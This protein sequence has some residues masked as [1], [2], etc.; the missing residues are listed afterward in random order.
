MV[1]PRAQWGPGGFSDGTD[2]SGIRFSHENGA[3]P[4]KFMPETMGGGGLIFDYDA[5]GWPDIFLVD[6]GSLVD[7]EAASRAGHRLYRNDLDGTFSDVTTGSGIG[8]SGFGMGACAADYDN[9]GQVDLYVTSFGP[10]VL[11]R[12]AGSGRFVDVTPTAGVGTPLWSASCAFG[13]IDNDGDAD[14]YVTHYVDFDPVDNHKFCGDEAEGGRVYCHPNVY[15]GLSDILYRNNG[16]GTFSDVSRE[17]GIYSTEGK[18]LGV[19]FGDY[20]DDGWVDI[21]VANDSVRNFLYHNQGDGTFVDEALVAGVAFGPNGMPLAGMGTDLGDVDGDGLE[22]FFVTN[23]SLQTHNLYR[24]L[25]GGIFDEITAR[26]GVGMATRP[27]V[28]FGTAFL[29]FDNDADLDLAVANGD[30]VDNIA[31]YYPDR[32]YPQRNLLLENTGGGAFRDLGEDAGEGFALVKV[33]RA[34]AVGDL[35]NDGD[36]DLVI[37]NNGQTADVL[38]NE[39]E[40]NHALILR[41]VGTRSSR[42]GIGARLRAWV[43]DAVMVREVRAGSSYLGQND[44]RVHFGTGSSSVVDRIEVRWPSGIVD[45]LEEIAADQIV[46]VVEGEGATDR[47]PFSARVR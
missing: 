3:S 1:W 46:T 8:M 11:Y 16:D 47:T 13:D 9:D 18:G 7:P 4:R 12:N 38:L 42:D 32:T 30:V 40:G 6:S 33:S 19:V 23:L 20:D 17:A 29:D 14:L 28:G 43:G 41:M 35:D 15:N 5:D 36:L 24:N 39:Q 44:L 26:S 21:Y 37:V 2:R 22:D 10:N 34:L 25:G 45:V 27:F 31:A